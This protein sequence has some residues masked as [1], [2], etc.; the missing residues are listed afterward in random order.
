MAQYKILF[1][2]LLVIILWFLHINLIWRE[3]VGF[4]GQLYSSL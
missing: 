4:Q 2:L 1:H 3:C